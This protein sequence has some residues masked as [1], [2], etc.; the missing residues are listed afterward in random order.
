MAERDE[1]EVGELAKT[2]VFFFRES[3]VFLN[4]KGGCRKSQHR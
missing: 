1:E 4:V 3:N 2:R